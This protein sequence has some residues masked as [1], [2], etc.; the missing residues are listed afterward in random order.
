[1]ATRPHDTATRRK[2]TWTPATI[3]FGLLIMLLG[4]WV[5]FVP[6]VGPYFDFGFFTESA[7]SFSVRHWE[8]LLAPGIVA[9]V[10]GLLLMTPA[11]GLGWLG[12]LMATAAGIWLVIGPSL[13]PLWAAVDRVQPLPHGDV[14]RALLWIG[15]FYGPGALITYLA[16]YGQGLVSRRTVVEE[17][18]VEERPASATRERVVREE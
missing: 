16:G 3:P 5:F 1:M 6:L 10:G 15:Y 2:R 8:L 13:Y 4:A 11:W 12:G 18:V 17:A 9:F 14:V 7:W